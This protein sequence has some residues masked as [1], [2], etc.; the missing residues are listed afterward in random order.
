MNATV[1]YRL[2]YRGS[3]LLPQKKQDEGVQAWVL[4]R[5]VVDDRDFCIAADDVAIFNYDSEATTFQRFLFDKG[6]IEIAP[7]LQEHFE[8]VDKARKIRS[9]P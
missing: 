2:V 6:V 4:E 9:H 1:K 5:R 7:E 8:L 3:K